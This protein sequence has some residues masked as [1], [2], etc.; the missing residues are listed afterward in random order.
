MLNDI[1]KTA[2]QY[3][4]RRRFTRFPVDR[5]VS[6]ILY[7]DSSP[8]VTIPGRCQSLSEGGL[9]AIMSQ[10]LRIGEVVN[11]E[12]ANGIRLYAAVRNLHGFTHGFEF[13]LVKD[14]QRAAILRL[15]RAR[16]T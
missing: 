6:A 1:D 12:V 11:L 14:N 10:Q 7:W 4:T 16:F 2:G 8:T 5:P 3:S 9:G 15:C 13:V